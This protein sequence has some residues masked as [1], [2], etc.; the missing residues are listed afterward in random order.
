MQAPPPVRE[1]SARIRHHHC[2]PLRGSIPL[3]VLQAGRTITRR[4]LR[5]QYH[6]RDLAERFVYRLK[7]FRRVA[8]R[9][10]KTARNFLAFVQFAVFMFLAWARSTSRQR[11]I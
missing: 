7:H 6:R 5:R 9:S 2:R 1:W 10:E 4:L 8:T 11:L 3:I